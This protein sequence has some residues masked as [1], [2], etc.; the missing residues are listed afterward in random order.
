VCPRLV[1]EFYGHMEVAQD[2]DRWIIFQ[3][4]VQGHTI[5][6]DPQ[7]ISTIIGVPVLHIS[8]NPFTEISEPPRLE[9]L[10]DFFGANPS[11]DERE[12]MLITRLVSSLPPPAAHEDC[13]AQSMAHIS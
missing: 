11:G 12:H 7:A 3:T 6:I 4:F 8:V 2:D 1:C 10:R 13:F 9:Q 5:Q